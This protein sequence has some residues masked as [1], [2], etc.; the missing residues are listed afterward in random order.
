MTRY[1]IGSCMFLDYDGKLFGIIT[2]GDLRRLLLR[3]KN[4]QYIN[5]KD[6]NTNFRFESDLNKF[7]S[8]V[9][10]KNTFIPVIINEE[11]IGIFRV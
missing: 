3:Q 5:I 1:K 8:E 11:L 2:D 7:L 10:K 6:I 4:L 9:T